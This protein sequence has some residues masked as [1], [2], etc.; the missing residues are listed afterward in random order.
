MRHIKIVQTS[1]FAGIALF[2]LC[3]SALADIDWKR[4]K[5]DLSI[6]ESIIDQF[7]DEKNVST[8]GLYIENHG[9]LLIAHGGIK[10]GEINRLQVQVIRKDESGDIA[11]PTNSFRG[12][13]RI[14]KSRDDKSSENEEVI[15]KFSMFAKKPE[16]SK[17]QNES[18][19]K[20]LTEFLGTYANAIGQLKDDDRVTILLN[21]SERDFHSFRS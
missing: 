16:A 7:F 15:F 6:Q 2:A 14:Y 10:Y 20:Q 5:R 8:T 9:V 11:T 12:T 21:S 13:W 1:L 4:M 17:D 18:L 3:T 19:K